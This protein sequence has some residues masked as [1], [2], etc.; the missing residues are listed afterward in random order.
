MEAWAAISAL[1]GIAALLLRQYLAGKQTAQE[2]IDVTN[3]QTERQALENGNIDAVVADQ[4][5]RV[6][7]ALGGGGWRRNGNSEEEHY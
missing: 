6:Q 1:L 3:I 4:H 7:Q 2:N 5:D